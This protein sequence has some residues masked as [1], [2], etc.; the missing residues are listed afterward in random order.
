[1]FSSTGWGYNAQRFSPLTQISRQTVKRLVPAWFY[2]LDNNRGEEGQ[3]LVKDGVIYITSYNKTVAV[4]A[5]TGKDWSSP[6]YCPP[7]TTRVVCCGI[8]NRGGA[9]FDGKLYRTTLDGNVLAQVG[10]LYAKIGHDENPPMS[11]PATRYG[12]SSY[13]STDGAQRQKPNVAL[14]RRAEP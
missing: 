9:L 6:M 1:M 4:D 8:E 7:Q 2:S 13:W 12:P 11:A 5:L 10:G 3:P 14:T